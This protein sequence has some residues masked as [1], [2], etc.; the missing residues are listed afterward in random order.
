[1]LP[2]G[3][4]LRPPPDFC[5]VVDGQPPPLPWPLLLP[6]PLL[7]DPLTIMASFSFKPGRIA[8]CRESGSVAPISGVERTRP[9]LQEA[10]D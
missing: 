8:G 1:M 6:C 10:G 5:P 7:F 9:F 4:L 2:G 3:L